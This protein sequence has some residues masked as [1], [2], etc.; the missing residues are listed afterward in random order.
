MIDP[1]TTV[2]CNFTRDYH[3]ES[4]TVL[5]KLAATRLGGNVRRTKYLENTS[6]HKMRDTERN[7]CEADYTKSK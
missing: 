1:G 7:R 4:R 5:V 6:R 2:L 3:P